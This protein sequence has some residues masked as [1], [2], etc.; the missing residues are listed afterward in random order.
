MNKVSVIVP[1]YFGE[2][3][4]E[5]ALKSI[6]KQTY[7][8]VEIVVVNDSSDENESDFLKKIQKTYQFVLIENKFNSGCARSLLAGCQQA[9]GDYICVLSQDDCYHPEKLEKQIDFLTKN[10]NLV[11]CY[12]GVTKINLNTGLEEKLC[13]QETVQR[14]QNG[15]VLERIYL[16]NDL[17]FTLQGLCIKRNV[18]EKYA[19]PIWSKYLLDDWPLH[20]K[21]FQEIPEKIGFVEEVLVTYLIH[22]ENVSNRDYRVL[23]MTVD[24]IDGFVPQHLKEKALKNQLAFIFP[25]QKKSSFLKRICHFFRKQKK[26]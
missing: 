10:K 3:F 22:S 20:I 4:V 17:S 19:Y 18:L 24:A 7:K 5:N 13:F 6:K 23:A 11:A 12:C 16:A 15:T 2:D 21:F 8:C 25:K 14:M 9:S 26:G 1:Y